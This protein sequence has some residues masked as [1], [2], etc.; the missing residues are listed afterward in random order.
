[1]DQEF[2]PDPNPSHFVNYI[3]DHRQSLKSLPSKRGETLLTVPAAGYGNKKVVF[4]NDTTVCRK[5]KVVF[6]KDT[7]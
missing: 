5:N 4:R 1:M 7:A 2:L 3:R 6:G